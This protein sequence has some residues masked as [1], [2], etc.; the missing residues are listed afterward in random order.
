MLKNKIILQTLV[1]LFFC[2]DAFANRTITIF[3][4]DNMSSAIIEIA[5]VFSQKNYI[6]VSVNFNPS[7][8]L[9]S[10]IDL[11]EAVDMVIT[12]NS[13]LTESLKKRGL[14][15]IY[16][17]AF[18]AKDHLALASFKDNKKIADLTNN[19]TSFYNSLFFLNKNKSKLII[20]SE[21]SSSGEYS[22]KLF[23]KLDLK[24]IKLFRK[25]KEDRSK[26]FF[27]NFENEDKFFLAL[28]S[29]INKNPKLK[30]ISEE[31]ETSV[32]FQ[33][34]VIAGDNME[35]AREFLKFLKSQTSKNIFL[36]NGFQI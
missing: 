15:D 19:K 23:S 3:A 12:A 27:N 21:E 30:I 11:G 31:K 10:S 6:T 2:F 16:N 26:N 14:V 28:A 9:V 7:S 18:V 22:Y 35:I 4:E 17:T 5:R 33:A 1:F 29:Q 24:D 34:L 25:I 32:Y 13:N 20:D 36:A 8:E